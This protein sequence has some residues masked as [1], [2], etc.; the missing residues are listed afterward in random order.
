MGLGF[1]ENDLTF[2]INYSNTV[3]RKL[4]IKIFCFKQNQKVIISDIDGTITK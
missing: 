4:S 3:V 2:H 1:Y